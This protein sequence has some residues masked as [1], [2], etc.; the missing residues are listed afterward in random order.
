MEHFGRD[1][2]YF[3]HVKPYRRVDADV[4]PSVSLRD[5]LDFSCV[6]LSNGTRR[7]RNELAMILKPRNAVGRAGQLL[8]AAAALWP[9]AMNADETPVAVSPGPQNGVAFRAGR[10]AQFRVTAENRGSSPQRVLALTSSSGDSPQGSAREFNA[11][12]FSRRTTSHPIFIPS[13]VGTAQTSQRLST[14]YAVLTSDETSRRAPQRLGTSVESTVALVNAR[15]VTGVISDLRSAAP[16][17]ELVTA[18]RRTQ[19][20]PDRLTELRVDLLPALA[21]GFDA[22]DQIVLA[23]DELA[24]N[25]GGLAALRHWLA[26]GGRLWVMLDRVSPETLVRLMGDDFSAAI[27]DQTAIDVVSIKD[28]RRLPRPVQAQP[29]EFDDPV[30]MLR[31]VTGAES[32]LAFEVGGWPAAFW[33]RVGRGRVLFTT[34]E[35][36]AWVGGSLTPKSATAATSTPLAALAGEFFQPRVALGTQPGALESQAARLVGYAT[37]GRRTVGAVL[38]ACVALAVMLAIWSRRWRRRSSFAWSLV[39]LALATS[40]GLLAMGAAT[41]SVVEPTLVSMQVVNADTARGE[42]QIAGIVGAFQPTQADGKVEG[43]NCVMA[44]DGPWFND[45]GGPVWIDAARWR[46]SSPLP[47]GFALQRC[48]WCEPIADPL[49]T[50]ATLTKLGIRGSLGA[51]YIE[52]L[53]NAVLAAPGAPMIT[54][55]LAGDGTF[56]AAHDARLEVDQFLVGQVW[57]DQS[58]RRLEG[59]RSLFSSP[60]NSAALKLDGPT[61]LFWT[62]PRQLPVT[63]ETTRRRVGDCLMMA[64]LQLL[65]PA[66]GSVVAIPAML[67][68]FESADGPDG[69]GATSAYSN[70]NREWVDGLVAATQI[71]LRFQAPQAAMP[72]T[73]K[74]A[75][76]YVDIAAPGRTVAIS[77]WRGQ[78]RKKVHSTSSPLARR[79]IATIDDPTLL[80][81]DLRGG[82]LLNIDVGQH[83]HE[84]DAALAKVGWRIERVWLEIDE[85]IVEPRASA[86]DIATASKRN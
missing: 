28:V 23:T 8:V 83:V 58:R 50:G 86:A 29:R 32:H 62:A 5:M 68:P 82:L 69:T 13:G 41:R 63:I 81:L 67:L 65:P 33:Q 16:V 9:P 79:L 31:V 45:A 53:G 7:P 66:S 78:Q 70:G 1:A 56:L 71:N 38:G 39:G 18:A 47:A 37:L 4:R 22:F 52:S 20:L 24:D 76:L 73:I 34:L 80:E 59:Y 40:T 57:D 51:Q 30:G 72:M 46:L 49:I 36:E 12:A 2:E 15:V 74:R 60:G 61:L 64:P 26:E 6:D 11:P 17:R 48:A 42:L 77:G 44:P 43:R 55:D 14:A 19:S 54:V 27:V 75:T 84:K 3:R 10:Y 21:A 35:P 25:P 85:A